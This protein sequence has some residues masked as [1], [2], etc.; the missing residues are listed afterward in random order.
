MPSA[1]RPSRGPAQREDDRDVW[2][3]SAYP[4]GMCRILD[5]APL[6]A[7]LAAPLTAPVTPETA[8]CFA[9]LPTPPTAPAAAPPT[10]DDVPPGPVDAAGE[11][12]D[13]GDPVG[14]DIPPVAPPP[15]MF[16]MASGPLSWE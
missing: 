11:P 14:P 16:I 4:Y 10:P 5:T 6:V 3:A 13:T 8:P 1:T 2:E 15:V 12:A 7:L 9:A